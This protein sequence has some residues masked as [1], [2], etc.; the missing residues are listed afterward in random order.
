MK[1]LNNENDFKVSHSF[2]IG[3]VEKQFFFVNNFVSKCF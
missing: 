1:S 3:L 2:F